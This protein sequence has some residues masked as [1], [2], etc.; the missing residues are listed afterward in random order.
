MIQYICQYCG[1][2]FKSKRSKSCHERL[3]KLNQNRPDI[4][5][6][7]TNAINT[8]NKIK[9]KLIKYVLFDRVCEYCHRHFYIYDIENR[10]NFPKCCSTKCS[11]GLSGSQ[12][13]KGTKICK[14]IKCNNEFEINKHANPNKFI[15]NGCKAK[16][17]EYN[18]YLKDLEKEKIKNEN[19][20]Q[21]KVLN[22]EHKKRI[23]T[24]ETIQKLREAGKKSAQ[25]QSET[26]RSKNEIKFCNLCENYFNNVEHNKPIFNGWDSDVII[27]DIKFA[28]LWNGKV[29]YEPIFGQKNFNRVTNRDKIKIKEIQNF[30]YIPY[31][32][33]DTGKFNI[34]FVQKKFEEFI[35][36]LKENKYI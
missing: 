16:T 8:N 19:L 23:L 22:N 14:C 34:N 6:L 36:F 29:H 35:N 1:K 13:N 15:C 10:K 3:C 4:T 24:D 17:K 21:I 33:K 5:Y 27:H 26:R 18:K 30:G 25:K 31:I 11:H 20:E 2:N 32:I 7:T 28:I 9:N 12:N